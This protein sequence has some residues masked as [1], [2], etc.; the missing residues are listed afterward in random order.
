MTGGCD[1]P[2]AMT[3]VD[4]ANRDPVE[5]RRRAQAHL[6]DGHHGDDVRSI[7]LRAIGVSL[8]VERR[9]I[10]AIG[11]LQDALDAAARAGDR[12]LTGLAALSL[13]LAEAYVGE[14]ERARTRIGSAIDDLTGLERADARF[15]RALICQ[16]LG[17]YDTAL[18]DYRAAI[19]VF[20][21]HGRLDW[22]A[23][24]LLNRGIVHAY[25]GNHARAD[26]DFGRARTCFERLDD[27]L[28]IASADHN[29]AWLDALRGA[30]V[31][32]IAG[33]GRAETELERAG[34]PI[35]T[36]AIDHCEAF[37]SA[38]LFRRAI[39]RATAA[40][41]ELGQ[42]GLTL[43]RAELL[44]VLAEACAHA[45]PD[46]AGT[47]DLGAAAAAEAVRLLAELDKP[48]WHLRARIAAL[49]LAGRDDPAASADRVAALTAELERAGLVGW[50]RE[51][52]LLLAR[53]L[54]D[55]GDD[56][57]A[58]EV[59]GTL[60]PER[61]PPELEVLW[62]LTS[63]ELHRRAGAGGPV[64]RSVGAGVRAIRRRQE[65]A[66]TSEV[67][68][69]VGHHLGAL[70]EIGIACALADDR[71]EEILHWS[72][73]SAWTPAPPRR[74]PTPTVRALTFE[75]RALTDEL[76]KQT[77]LDDVERRRQLASRQRHL[78]RQL[79]A[80]LEGMSST[81]PLADPGTRGGEPT[82]VAIRCYAAVDGELVL[83]HNRSG[84]LATEQLGSIDEVEALA[85]RLGFHLRG[86]IG[87]AGDRHTEATETAAASLDRALGH[88]GRGSGDRPVDVFLP[89]RLGPMPLA[90]LPSLA[91]RD[92]LITT[93]PAPTRSIAE[94]G[95]ETGERQVCVIAGPDLASAGD[96]AR[97]V[98]AIHRG[99]EILTGP[100][101]TCAAVQDA[102]MRADVV[103]VAAHG[104]RSDD[105][106]FYDNL[107]LVDGPLFVHD[108]DWL[109]RAPR[110]VVLATC[111][112]AGH[113]SVAGGQRLGLTPSLERVGVHR[114][115]ASVYPLPDDE[116]VVEVMERLHRHLLV[117]D[118]P[119]RAL[120]CT[121]VDPTLDDRGR[122]IASTLICSGRSAP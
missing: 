16:L 3:L 58:N 43:E 56:R 50:A 24:L 9:P 27:D 108:L 93:T 88:P 92:V 103:H 20:R 59:L 69:H 54:V 94:R 107:A 101:A 63:A 112:S 44:V 23:D 53:M 28:G 55:R 18:A 73:E 57:R 120:A 41:G 7:L 33:Y 39:D 89:P 2:E 25:R 104:R 81:E 29:S 45:G 26:A 100:G 67:R 102:M 96:E 40:I 82:P 30:T 12:R 60:D 19:G 71:P 51:A 1:A 91:G 76:L 117:E 78:Q 32:A 31:A 68:A 66:N 99:A 109:D 77:D 115:I 13:A 95:P 14:T 87:P 114:T 34:Y 36:V 105:D 74:A 111:E 118:D 47:S 38:G 97:A 64:A 110:V 90:A 85:R 8:R 42:R 46:G 80:A 35:E 4:L 121:V 116:S 83:I 11:P 106:P 21:R 6:D 86:A 61:L 98:A 52:T 48:Q 84:R 79:R 119:I 5:A 113:H 49:R 62:W 37:V 72:Q 15:Q 10:E 70:A 122:A 17:D 75:L 65:A 22:E